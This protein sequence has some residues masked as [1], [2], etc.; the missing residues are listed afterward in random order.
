VTPEQQQKLVEWR[1]SWFTSWR[2]CEPAKR[3]VVQEAITTLYQSV[4]RDRPEFIWARSPAEAVEISGREKSKLR[5][6]LWAALRDW[7]QN[8]AWLLDNEQRLIYDRMFRFA[9]HNQV[10][11]SPDFPIDKLGINFHYRFTVERANA[12]DVGVCAALTFSRDVLGVSGRSP[13]ARWTPLAGADASPLTEL[14][15][16]ATIAREVWHWWPFRDACIIS[17]R[18]SR[19]VLDDQARMHNPA[20]PAV[21]YRDG[22]SA[23][24]VRGTVIPSEWIKNTKDI[25]VETALTWPNVEQRRIAAELIGWA[26]VIDRLNPVIVDQNVN[27]QIGTLLSVTMPADPAAPWQQPAQQLFLRVRCGTNR[28][29]V[30]PVPREMRTALQANAWTYDVSEEELLKL[31][32]RT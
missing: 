24:A 14:N 10:F 20:G 5:V 1:E 12:E 28:E 27:P 31:E 21:V 16:R 2:S 13:D 30:L 4:K 9:A 7:Q 23:Y 22:W 11:N 19:L 8:S 32:V 18:P 25:P 6:S 29:F 26:K 3:D 15:A 17:E